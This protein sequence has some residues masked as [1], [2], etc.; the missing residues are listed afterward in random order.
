[1]NSVVRN[2]SLDFVNQKPPHLN[3]IG[4]DEDYEDPNVEGS[5]SGDGELVEHTL[6]MRGSNQTVQYAK[7]VTDANPEYVYI[8]ILLLHHRPKCTF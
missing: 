3:N 1:M 5:G 7:N 8:S 6:E 4:D 2:I